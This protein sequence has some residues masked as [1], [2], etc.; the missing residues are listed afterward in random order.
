MLNKSLFEQDAYRINNSAKP[1]VIP[2]KIV[3]INIK[4][5]KSTKN[6]CVSFFT[7]ETKKIMEN[8][9]IN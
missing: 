3:E 5:N 4:N 2:M 6:L 9:F 8:I 1:P 7:E